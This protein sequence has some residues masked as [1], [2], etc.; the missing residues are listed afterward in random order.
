MGRDVSNLKANPQTL[1][2][3]F[4]ELQIKGGLLIVVKYKS[5]G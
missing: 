2:A 3:E 5:K 4:E 1:E